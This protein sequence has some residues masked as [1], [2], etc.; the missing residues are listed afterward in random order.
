MTPS[1]QDG[2]QKPGDTNLP[3]PVPPEQWAALRALREGEP[4]I[5]A[6]LAAASGIHITT[7][8]VQARIE[9]WEGVVKVGRPR[10]GET[11]KTDEEAADE[12]E[13][14]LSTPAAEG[15]AE[16]RLARV[17]DML[18]REVETI[19]L[20]AQARGKMPDKARIDA[21]G[22]MI[23]LLEKVEEFARAKGGAGE[24]NRDGEVAD[25]LQR[26]DGRIEE[27]A[28]AYAKELVAEQRFGAGSGADP[29]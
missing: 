24:K 15:T 20:L 9:G 18:L 5:Y 13:I 28:R 19:G 17:S 16:E 11:G 3:P 1:R 29:R 14:L 22:A 25:V 26:I 10:K 4:P 21:V 23:R 2:F 7:I 27:L 6:R 12:A 8:K